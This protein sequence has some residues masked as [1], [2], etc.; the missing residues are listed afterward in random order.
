MTHS[1][2][3]RHVLGATGLAM[4]TAALPAF[5]EESPLAE[6]PFLENLTYLAGRIE[7]ARALIAAGQG[8]VA[9]KRHLGPALNARIAKMEDFLAAKKNATLL[10]AVASLAEAARTPA[11]FAAAHDKVS[12]ELLSA[13][14]LVPA[15]KL[16]GKAFLGAVLANVAAHAAEDYEAAISAGQIKIIKEYEEVY[17]YVRA[18][19]SLWQRR[20]ESVL[21]AGKTGQIIRE[22]ASFA[23]SVI[24]PAALRAPAEMTVLVAEMKKAAAA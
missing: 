10:P 8:E 5:A 13:E 22:L 9:L 19:G 14:T 12:A 11:Q 4:L 16:A 7:A 6:G 15:D 24:P 3:R 17:G 1:L 18:L 2:T 23:P 20:G 21:G